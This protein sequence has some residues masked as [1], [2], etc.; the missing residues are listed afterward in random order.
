MDNVI[1]LV[2]SKWVTASVLA[3]ITGMK[4]GTIKKARENSWAV[5]REYLHISPY[6]KPN[7]KS[8]CMYNHAAVNSWIEKQRDAQPI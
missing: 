2:P 1:N 3:A 5:G 6:G 8:E 4:P 7:E